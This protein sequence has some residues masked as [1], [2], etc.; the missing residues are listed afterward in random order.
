MIAAVAM[1]AVATAARFA[2]LLFGIFGRLWFLNTLTRLDGIAAGI[3]LASLVP[4]S[5]TPLR[6]FSRAALV[7][8]GCACWF[9]AARYCEPPLALSLT[10]C[11][12]AVAVGNSAACPSLMTAF[13]SSYAA[14]EAATV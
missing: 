13:A 14:A 11:Y 1:L 9:F 8:G 2:V 10:L 6:F 3:L 12:P 4:P 7:I 5:V